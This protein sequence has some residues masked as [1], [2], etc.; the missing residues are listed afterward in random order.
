MPETRKSARLDPDLAWTVLTDAPLQGLSFAREAGL[1]F[2][3][4]EGQQ[5]YLL[6]ASGERRSA[7]RAPDRILAGAISDNGALIALL[8]KGPRLWLLTADLEPIADRPVI[9]EPAA[10]AVDPHGRYVA[11]ASKLNTTQFYNRHGRQAGRFTTRQS[12]A[13]LCFVAGQPFLLGTGAY[14]VIL[15]VELSKEGPTGHLGGEIVWEQALMS[16]VGRLT[17]TGDGGAILASCFTHGVQRYDLRGHNEGSYHLGGTASHAVPDYAGR[18]IV[19]ATLEGELAI[20]NGGGNVRWKTALP[21]AVVGLEFD[22]LGRYLVYGLP[23]GEI[24]RLDLEGSGRAAAPTVALSLDSGKGQRSTP[25]RPPEWTAPVAQT[26]EQ[27]EAAAL[28]VLDSPPLI[29]FLT[30]RNQLQIFTEGGENLG[31][32]PELAGVGRLLRTSPG[33][34]AAATDRNVVL[35]DARRNTMQRLDLSLVELTHLAS[36]PDTYGLGLVQERDRLGRATPAG[37]WIWKRELKSAVEDLAIGPGGSTAV[38]TEAGQLLVFDAAGEPAGAFSSEQ[39]EGLLLTAAPRDAPDPVSWITLSRRF[40]TLLGH[41]I[42]G[43]VVWETPIPWEGWQLH[44]V[45]PLVIVTSADGKCLAYDGAGQLK[46]QSRDAA[47]RGVYCLGPT[48]DAWVVVRQGV[49]LICTDLSGHVNWRAVA[50]APL[51]PLAAGESG[52]AAMIG[53]SLAWFRTSSA[54]K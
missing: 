36:R 38:T 43:Q 47:P 14:G 46:G 34:I 54:S 29:A 17:A 8:G 16:N 42:R 9:S 40:Q 53:R 39:G 51:G 15:A 41:D 31:Q 4:D 18:T 44:E 26:D 12:L 1:I 5:L 21:R 11:V 35:Y 13:H 20:L 52:V 10:L 2:A 33:W 6:D 22:A 37:R 32:G 7:S 28:A 24:S 23:T 30:G 25:I 48:G 49:H 50:D 45:G 27:A 3:W 19:V